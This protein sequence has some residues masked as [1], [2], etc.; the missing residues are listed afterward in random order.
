MPEEAQP[1]LA[2][3]SLQ[4][5][6]D[7][8]SNKV[9]GSVVTEAYGKPY[10]NELGAWVQD[11]VKYSAS[12]EE[13][14]AAVKNRL[15][16]DE[17]TRI[18][19]FEEFQKYVSGLPLEQQMAIL[20]RDKSGKIDAGDYS[21]SQMAD[22]TNPIIKFAQDKYWQ[23]ARRAETDKGKRAV[24]PP[25]TASSTQGKGVPI[26]FGDQPWKTVMP[27][28]KRPSGGQYSDIV[29]PEIYSFPGDLPLDN[30]TISTDAKRVSGTQSY[31][32][33]RTGKTSGKLKDYAIDSNGNDWII[34][35]ATTS[36]N[37]LRI[38]SK[39]DL[40]IPV[41]DILE[42]PALP[43]IDASGKQTTVGELRG[44]PAQ[45]TTTAPTSKWDKYLKK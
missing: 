30:V 29:Y 32:F 1:E 13:A 38:E 12:E 9:Q 26:K 5:F 44:K 2:G 16:E 35:E 37:D 20:D 22:E 39:D 25:R 11:E 17:A 45:S 36:D 21:R 10:K 31:N 14:R 43:L 42:A 23:I 7:T 3:K 24:T 41:R 19:T 15:L 8:S 40:A 33:S 27:A 18:A 6:Y 28:V 34:L 4:G